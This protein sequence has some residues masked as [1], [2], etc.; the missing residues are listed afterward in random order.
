MGKMDVRTSGKSRRRA[1]SLL[2]REGRL[3]YAK[4]NTVSGR[5]KNAPLGT[6]A[7]AKESGGLQAAAPGAH[8]YDRKEE[9]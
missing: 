2:D 9:M 6:R 5:I 8:G 1:K 7:C 4:E 3:F